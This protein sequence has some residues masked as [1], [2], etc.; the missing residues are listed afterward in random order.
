MKLFRTNSAALP[1]SEETQKNADL[2][3]DSGVERQFSDE[4]LRG[5]SGILLLLESLLQITD[6]NELVDSPNLV[7]MDLGGLRQSLL[8]VRQKNISLGQW[9]SVFSDSWL[10][11]KSVSSN[12][13]W[14]KMDELGN[15]ACYSFHPE[16]IA[17]QNGVQTSQYR[18]QFT[19]M[20][21]FTIIAVKEF[22]ADLDAITKESL[23]LVLF[24]QDVI[25]TL[26]H[27]ILPL[28]LAT[29]E[30]KKIKEGIATSLCNLNLWW[31]N[32]RLTIRKEHLYERKIAED[33]D[34]IRDVIANGLLTK[35]PAKLM[36]LLEQ[37][38]QRL[39]PII[40]LHPANSCLEIHTINHNTRSIYTT[41]KSIVDELHAVINGLDSRKT[42]VAKTG[43]NYI[44]DNVMVRN[45]ARGLNKARTRNFIAETR[46]RAK[47][48]DLGQD[49]VMLP[50]S[51]SR[52]RKSATN[53]T[54]LADGKSDEGGSSK[55]GA[56]SRQKTSPRVL[57][58]SKSSSGTPEPKITPTF[59]K[60]RSNSAS[61]QFQ[62]DDLPVVAIINPSEQTKNTASQ[63]RPG[64]KSPLPRTSLSLD[65]RS[66][67]Q[68]SSAHDMSPSKDDTDQ[69][70]P[71][72]ESPHDSSGVSP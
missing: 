33:I 58:T 47:S 48:A 11:D 57:L 15:L 5:T 25:D 38:I 65:L 66:L 68:S 8:N 22:K 26:V 16:I 70:N 46:N 63:I 13:E 52:Q 32:S 30:Y 23:Y 29:D 19:D 28:V 18:R 60:R 24:L 43:L 27:R 3:R 1:S 59:S 49:V 35:L 36:T 4:I 51:N 2:S 61:P 42:P 31:K 64:L 37:S 7:K 69:W 55:L 34:F 53:P 21:A 41:L 54:Y 62:A 39:A 12:G 56:N 10:E 72:S 67:T 40:Q 20:N 45:A 44:C 14:E 50:G 9:E 17:F 71:D 6:R